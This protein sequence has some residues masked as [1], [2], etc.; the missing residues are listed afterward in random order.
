LHP[1]GCQPD[2]NFIRLVA[3]RMQTSDKF[4]YFVLHGRYTA[5][6]MITTEQLAANRMQIL[7]KY[8]AS[9]LLSR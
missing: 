6:R 9:T 7:Q 1:V 8:A 2:A 4:G 3:S 5:N